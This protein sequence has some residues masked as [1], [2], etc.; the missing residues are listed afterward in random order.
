MKK[1]WEEIVLKV[2]KLASKKSFEADDTS[3][4]GVTLLYRIGVIA[5]IF[6]TVAISVYSYL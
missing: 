5:V 2:T 4:L 3:D 6:T 1:N